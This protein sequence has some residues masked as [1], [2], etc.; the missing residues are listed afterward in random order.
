MLGDPD[1]LGDQPS[2]RHCYYY[3][4]MFDYAPKDYEMVSLLILANAGGPIY[5][6]SLLT[7]PN[8]EI[9]P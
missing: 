1:L 4:E 9:R 6:A 8:S 7:G 5:E 3:Y 2:T